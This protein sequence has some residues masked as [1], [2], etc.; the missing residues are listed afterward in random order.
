M[1]VN[2]VTINGSDVLDL[3]S[4]TAT[5]ADVASGKTFHL[6]SG[7]QATGT[8]A[9]PDDY[10]VETGTSGIWTY[11]KWNSG[12]SECWGVLEWTLTAQ[13]AWG[14]MYYAT[15]ES[16]AQAYPSGLFVAVPSETGTINYRNGDCLTARMNNTGSST[17]SGRYYAMRPASFGLNAKAELSMHAI[18]R[19]Q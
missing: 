13:S 16:T 10:V 4:D 18:G 1:A 17:T 6:A 14:S 19:W 3:T 12:V 11:R 8:A 7:L 5:A 15:P 2:K 9:T